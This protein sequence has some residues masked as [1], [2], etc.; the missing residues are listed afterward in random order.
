MQSI[1]QLLEILWQKA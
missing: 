1:Y